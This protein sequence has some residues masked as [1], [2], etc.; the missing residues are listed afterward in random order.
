MFSSGLRSRTEV[1]KIIGI[2][3]IDD[4]CHPE[5]FCHAVELFVEF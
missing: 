5:L 4:H 3:S 2:R 1:R